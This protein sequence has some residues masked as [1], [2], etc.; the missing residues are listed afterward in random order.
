METVEEK[1][2]I[3]GFHEM[4]RTSVDLPLDASDT[5]LKE[6]QNEQRPCLPEKAS[7]V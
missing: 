2:Q 7:I 5:F 6:L 1:E 3:E 4:S